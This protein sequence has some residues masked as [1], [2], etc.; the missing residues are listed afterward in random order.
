MTMPDQNLR[1]LK[2]SHKFLSTLLTARKQTFRNMSLEEFETWHKE[3]ISCIHHFPFDYQLDKLY[4]KQVCIEC[5]EPME[6]HKMG[7]SAG[8]LELRSNNKGEGL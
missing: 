6:F 4:E 1:A 2:M 3:A 7:C 5:G 8:A